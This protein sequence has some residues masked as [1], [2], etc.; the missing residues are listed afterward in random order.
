MGLAQ[1]LNTFATCC[2]SYD[3]GSIFLGLKVNT[4]KIAKTAVM[5]IAS[6]ISLL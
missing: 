3:P 5:T 4:K 2:K 6:R 1:K